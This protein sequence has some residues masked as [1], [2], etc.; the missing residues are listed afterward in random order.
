MVVTDE[1]KDIFSW[2]Y[3][4]IFPGQK[5]DAADTLCARQVY[6]PTIRGGT[7]NQAQW[8]CGNI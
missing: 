5:F 2:L 7:L 1:K 6:F 4:Q 8:I 3:L